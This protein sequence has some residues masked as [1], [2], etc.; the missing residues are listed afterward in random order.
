MAK[1]KSTHPVVINKEKFLLPKM[2]FFPLDK[3]TGEGVYIKEIGGKSLL[4]CKELIEKMSAE[5]GEGADLSTSQGIELMVFFVLKSACYQDGSPFFT[6][7]DV[8]LLA[9]KSPVL[10]QDMADKAMLLAGM[11]PVAVT[12]VKKTLPNAP[13]ASSSTN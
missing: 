2:E 1:R 7:E 10:L 6:E 9:E 13:I 12:E 5:A 3:A 8:A 4:E 11:N